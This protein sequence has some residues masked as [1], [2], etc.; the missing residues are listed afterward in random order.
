M[1][2]QI[3]EM[4]EEALTGNR[5][6]GATDGQ[7][8][9]VRR[10][11]SDHRHTSAFM[12]ASDTSNADERVCA[13]CSKPIKARDPRYRI[14]EAEYHPDCFKCCLNVPRPDDAIGWNRLANALRRR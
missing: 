10:V 3:I 12:G 9:T 1:Y 7:P 14:G 4:A 5:R 2:W 13:V 11:R 6:H 8:R